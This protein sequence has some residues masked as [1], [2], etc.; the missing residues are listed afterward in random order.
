MKKD[1]ILNKKDLS[2]IKSIRNREGEV[3]PFDLN[4]I[5]DAVIKAFNATGEGGEKE[6]KNVANK[7][8]NALV[9]TKGNTN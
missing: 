8:F 7:V 4:K 3:V 6:S 5:I 2:K 1:N 9:F